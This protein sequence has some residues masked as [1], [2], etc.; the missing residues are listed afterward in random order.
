MTIKAT[1][2]RV[3]LATALSLFTGAC[4]LE[5]CEWTIDPGAEPA[6]DDVDAAFAGDT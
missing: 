3:A 2:R 6:S 5:R 1:M 4:F